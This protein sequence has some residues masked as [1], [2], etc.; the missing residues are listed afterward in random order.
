M[1]GWIDDLARA[2]DLDPLTASETDRLLRI[3]RDVA[4]RVERKGAPLASFLLG[5]YVAG[6]TADGSARA[7]AL[8]EAIASTVVLLPPAPEEP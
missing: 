8:R 4:H 3:A 7:S 6:R 5:M 1:S 2:L